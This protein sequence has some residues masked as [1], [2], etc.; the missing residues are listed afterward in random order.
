M[1]FKS[2]SSISSITI[3]DFSDVSALLEEEG[4]PKE[5]VLNYDLDNLKRLVKADRLPEEIA[6]VIQ[7]QFAETDLDTLTTIVTRYHEQDT[8]K[9]DL[10]FSEDA[11]NLLQNI[12]AVSFL[13]QRGCVG[14]KLNRERALTAPSGEKEKAVYF[15]ALGMDAYA[16]QESNTS[17]SIP[18]SA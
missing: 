7:P 11:F 10:V 4:F 1:C 8:W 18:Y 14:F 16:L 2:P 12:L 9:E 15:V 17:C 5:L 6:K 13:L 3:G